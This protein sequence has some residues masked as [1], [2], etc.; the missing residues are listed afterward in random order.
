ML[1]CC[2][3]STKLNADH[4]LCPKR[5]MRAGEPQWANGFSR[6]AASHPYKHQ[7]RFTCAV[8]RLGDQALLGRTRRCTGEVPC[9]DSALHRQVETHRPRARKSLSA[10]GCKCMIRMRRAARSHQSSWGG[11]GGKLRGRL[12]LALNFAIAAPADSHS[13]ETA[14]PPSIADTPKNRA[15]FQG[16]QNVLFTPLKCSE[17]LQLQVVVLHSR[18]CKGHVWR[19]PSPSPTRRREWEARHYRARATSCGVPS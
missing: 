13:N 18:G 16:G 8:Q 2:A 9:N 5:C 3:A 6:P 10:L 19:R 12:A 1:F 4:Q 17:C 11:R 15:A 14:A 7:Q